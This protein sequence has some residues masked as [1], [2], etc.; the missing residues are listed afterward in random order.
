MSHAL[1]WQAALA[2]DGSDLQ[3]SKIRVNLAV[4]KETAHLPQS[5]CHLPLRDLPGSLL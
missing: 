1:A 5:G 3:G 4:D 2:L